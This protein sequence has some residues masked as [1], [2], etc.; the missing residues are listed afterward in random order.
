M[1]RAVEKRY[2]K[3]ERKY[4]LE[5][6]ANLS[7]FMFDA[8]KQAKVFHVYPGLMNLELMVGRQQRLLDP[9][10]TLSLIM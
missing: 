8:S 5:C 6:V 4:F 9:N 1:K 3:E 7:Y 10:T 2:L